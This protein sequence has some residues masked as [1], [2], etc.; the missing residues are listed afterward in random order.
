MECQVPE[1]TGRVWGRGGAGSTR[2]DAGESELQA[3][4]AVKAAPLTLCR[5]VKAQSKTLK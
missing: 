3:R 5:K 1:V 4:K 2:A